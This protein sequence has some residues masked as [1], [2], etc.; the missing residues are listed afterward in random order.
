MRHHTVLPSQGK[1]AKLQPTESLSDA[2][3][4]ASRGTD[5]SVKISI[6]SYHCAVREKFE[7]LRCMQVEHRGWEE[8]RPNVIL[9]TTHR[10]KI[11]TDNQT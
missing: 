6:Y 9:L 8:H 5:E 11:G 4:A 10:E 3:V 2:C 7:G 1:P